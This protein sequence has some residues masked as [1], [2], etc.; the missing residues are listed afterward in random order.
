MFFYTVN[1][2]TKLRYD[3]DTIVTAPMNIEGPTM[4]HNLLK[5][6]L[7]ALSAMILMS[8]QQTEEKASPDE[9]DVKPLTAQEED[10]LFSQASALFGALPERMP[11]SEND[12]PELIALGEDLYFETAL[13]EN[14]SQSCNTCHMVNDGFAGVDNEVTSEGAHG[15]RGERNSP[16]VLNAG[17]HFVQFWDGRAEDLVEQAK[18]PILNPVEMAMA[19]EEAVESR[20][21]EDPDYQQAFAAAFPDQ[22][23]PITY[24]NVAEAIAAFERTLISRSRF[25]DYMD[26]DRAALTAAEKRGLQTYVSTGCITCHM[27]STFGGTMYQKLGLVNP[28]PSEDPGRYMVTNDPADSMMFKVPSLRNVALTAPYW[29][30]GSVATLEEAVELM[31]WHQLGRKLEEKDV[32][33]IVAFLN[34]LSDPDRKSASEESMEVAAK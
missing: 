24:Q 8:C 7:L 33:L 28:Y 29:H 17:Y 34:S 9:L 20:L 27:Q 3:V 21:S 15:E 2:V 12:T 19:S 32:D 30:D 31:A 11:G 23:N 6:L 16:T 4:H 26:G 5:A 18:G 13:S 25:D 10:E 1:L 22:K 14:N